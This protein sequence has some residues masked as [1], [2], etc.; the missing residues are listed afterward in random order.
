MK[1]ASDYENYKLYPLI[2]TKDAENVIK[3]FENPGFEK[4]PFK[5][6]RIKQYGNYSAPHL[7]GTLRVPHALRQPGSAFRPQTCR[8]LAYTL[9]VG[10]D[11]FRRDVFMPH[12]TAVSCCKIPA[13]GKPPCRGAS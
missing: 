5:N 4:M 7:L 1:E 2:V 13:N 9:N 10:A 6:N 8:V 3:L 12:T 11:S